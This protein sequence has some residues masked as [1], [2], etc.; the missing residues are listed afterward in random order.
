MH[1]SEFYDILYHRAHIA[2]YKIIIQ[3]KLF[4]KPIS[5]IVQNFRLI[6]ALI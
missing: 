6:L 1:S 5:A 3:L 4:K 2:P